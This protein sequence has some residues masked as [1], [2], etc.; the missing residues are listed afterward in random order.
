M[1]QVN[2]YCTAPFAS[3]M[4]GAILCKGLGRAEYDNMMSLFEQGDQYHGYDMKT[5]LQY[6]VTSLNQACHDDKRCPLPHFGFFR[7]L[8]LHLYLFCQTLSCR[9]M[10][11]SKL[12]LIYSPLST[13]NSISLTFG[14]KIISRCY[15]LG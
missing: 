4:P 10:A 11:G 14:A 12:E 6:I 15:Y 9:E 1:L 2:F 7:V 8:Y 5:A 13:A 3:I